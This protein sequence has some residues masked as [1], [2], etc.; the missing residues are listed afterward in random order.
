LFDDRNI[1]S[2]VN[3]KRIFPGKWSK[4]LQEMCELAVRA[5]AQNN[6][7]RGESPDRLER[8]SRNSRKQQKGRPEGAEM[9]SGM[10]LPFIVGIGA[11]EW[12]QKV[13]FKCWFSR[14]I[15]NMNARLARRLLR[16]LECPNDRLVTTVF[17]PQP[18]Q[19]RLEV[20]MP[21]R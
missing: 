20:S 4:F 2:L 21:A 14:G 1:G 18:D 8:S 15:S 7:P 17:D 13:R 10:I 16:K 12:E 6:G 5:P 9:K 11:F 3:Q 19:F